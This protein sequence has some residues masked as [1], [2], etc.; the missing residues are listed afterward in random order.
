MKFTSIPGAIFNEFIASGLMLITPEYRALKAVQKRSSDEMDAL[1]DYKM[2]FQ[3]M[4]IKGLRLR[5][6]VAGN[7]SGPAILFLSP[8]P[9]SIRCF[10]QIWP[11]LAKK[12]RL[13]GLDLPG[14]GRSEGG[15][16]V[17]NTEAQSEILDLFV[18]ELGIADFHLVGPDVGMP[19]ALHYA[20]HRDHRLKSL[21]LGDGPCVTPSHNGSIIDRAVTSPL[22]RLIFKIG[23]AG[24]FVVGANKLA[25]VNYSPS[26]DEVEDYFASYRGRIPAIM[27][28]F[29]AY[30][31]II[32]TIEPNLPEID[33]PIQIFWGEDDKLLLVETAYKFQERLKNAKLRVFEECGHFSYQDKRED[34]AQMINDWVDGGHAE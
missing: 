6:S 24:P 3:F 29:K 7:E 10:E 5:Y 28:W 21:V 30:P 18:R 4:T 25:Y 26:D 20:I 34:F 22:W 1:T 33:L 23:G 14:F 16:E 2:S 27:Q 12:F 15:H 32:G 8:L 9:Q 17:M 11:S 13:I 31:E 19:V